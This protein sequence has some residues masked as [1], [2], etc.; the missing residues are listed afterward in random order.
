M[1]LNELRD[2]PGANKPRK[3]VGRGP[4]SGTGK[5]CG[6]GQK[7]QKSRTGVAI[8]G[9]EGGQTPLFRRLPKR[10]FNNVFRTEYQAVNTGQLQ[11]FVDAKKLDDK[12]PITKEVLVEAGIIRNKDV[13]V[14]LLAEGDIKASL[15]LEVEKASKSAISKIEA[16]KGKVTVLNAPV[17]SK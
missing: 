11:K 5:T 15:T 6:H 2:N 9:F 14:K 12:K 13:L 7:G 4:A 8:K 10:G 16:A 3:R 17:E 1:K